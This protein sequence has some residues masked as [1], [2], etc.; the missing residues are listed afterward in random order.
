MVQAGLEIGQGEVGKAFQQQRQGFG[1]GAVPGQLDVLES[2][3]GVDG[4]FEGNM[5]WITTRGFDARRFL[6]FSYTLSNY[7]SNYHY[8][9]MRKCFETF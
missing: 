9:S 3:V 7:L 4:S 6:F 2:G 8:L 5:P 1:L